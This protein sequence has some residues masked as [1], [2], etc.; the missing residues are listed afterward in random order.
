MYVSFNP[1]LKADAPLFSVL[2]NNPPAWWKKILAN[3]RLYVEIRKDNYINVYYQGGSIARVECV[4]NKVTLKAHPKYMG[5]YDKSDRTFYRADGSPVYAD[6]ADYL[7]NHMDE[8]LRNV[9]RAYSNKKDKDCENA[10]NIS[11]KKIQ[12]EM[13][14]H[15]RGEYLDSELECLFSKEYD[16]AGKCKNRF[17]RID[18]VRVE[19][20]HLQFVELKRIQDS[21]L[22]NKDDSDPEIVTQ[23]NNYS[24][25]VRNNSEMLLGYYRTLYGIKRSLGLPVP[26]IDENSLSVDTTPVLLIKNLYGDVV[27]TRRLARISRIEALLRKNGI[28]Y[29]L[30]K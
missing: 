16:S 23:M 20:N 4:S 28:T 17:I 30:C 18:M 8:M 6:C 19:D 29:K 1:A 10:E 5:H 12:G 14:I 2:K 21:R 13:I 3:D 11:E 26:Y 9:E 15:G 25:F 7:E 22:L 27:G 24:I